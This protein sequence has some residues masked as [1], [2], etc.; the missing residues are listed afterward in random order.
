M[1]ILR[2]KIHIWLGGLALFAVL[3]V[4]SMHAEAAHFL[5]HTDP[6]DFLLRESDL[7][8][9]GKYAIPLHERHVISNDLIVYLL[10]DEAGEERIRRTGRIVGW[11]V[12]YTRG[13]WRAPVPEEFTQT[14][15]Q[16]ASAQGARLNLKEYRLSTWYPEEGWR[17]ADLEMHLGDAALVETRS[18]LMQDGS[19]R[20][21]YSVSFTYRNI[22]VRL[23]AAGDA[24][25][26]DLEE[27]I[28]QAN[29]VLA[30][31][32]AA[33]LRTGPV[34][35]PTPGFEMPEKGRPIYL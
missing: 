21:W 34:P 24:G 32:A 5:I 6:R 23:E 28:A 18:R 12:H 7:P 19:R 2:R 4:G 22:G 9:E 29:T 8:P 17:E 30:R 13:D 25:Q 11:R 16:Y 14:V 27:L 31:L 1:N 26:V 20:V 10:G 3:I 35:T 33:E 15:T